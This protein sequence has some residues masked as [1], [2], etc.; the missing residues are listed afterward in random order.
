MLFPSG[1]LERESRMASVEIK[2]IRLSPPAGNEALFL[3]GLLQDSVR[4][5]CNS[6]RR[7]QVIK[8]FDDNARDLFNVLL[9]GY[10]WLCRNMGSFENVHKSWFLLLLIART[11]LLTFAGLF[12]ADG[13]GV[14]PVVALLAVVAVPSRRVVPASDA[15]RPASLTRHLVKFQTESTLP[16]VSITM[17]CCRKGKL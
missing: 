14:V 2:D 6:R 10:E 16:C 9:L 11:D 5:S 17:A 1:L 4:S 15:H 7:R 8:I 13:F 12:A 3:K